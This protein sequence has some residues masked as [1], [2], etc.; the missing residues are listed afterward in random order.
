LFMV[1]SV[2]KVYFLGA[3]PGSALFLT[4]AGQALLNTADVVIYDALIDQ[5]LLRLSSESCIYLC[6]GKRGHQPSTAQADINRLL[7]Q[8]CRQGKQ[9]IRLKS[10]DPMFFGRIASE[11]SA[12]QAADCAYEVWPGLSSAI[13]APALAGI[14]LT[15]PDHSQMVTLVS[16][17]DLTQLNWM[18]LAQSETL[19]IL[20]GGRSLPDIVHR[21]QHQGRSRETPIAI[22]RWAGHPQQRLWQGTLDTIVAITEGESLSPTVMVIGEVVR[23]RDQL[24]IPVMAGETFNDM[25]IHRAHLN[26]PMSL[27]PPSPA[28]PL[29]GKTILVT[30]AAT[31]SGQF[32]DRLRGLGATVL[33]MAA[34]E[35]VAPS[36][37]EPLDRAIAQ[38]QTFD[39]LI[40]TSANGVEFFFQRL[41]ELGQDSRALATVKV[42]VVGR[43]TAEVLQQQGIVPDF[44]PP[45]Y[46]ADALVEHFPGGQNLQGLTCLFPRVESGGRET[47]TAELA[48]QGVHITEVAAY[49]SQCPKTVHPEVLD[50]LQQARVDVITFASSK[51]V[52]HFCQLLQQATG[53]EKNADAAPWRSWLA[54]V[55]IASIGPQTSRSCEKLLG[56]VD[57]EATEFTLD[58]L[59]QAMLDDSGHL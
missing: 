50:A 21:L 33:E 57:V 31:Q 7:V 47:L 5:K 53:M 12:L 8:Y 54:A 4:I 10:G 55:K 13:A 14:P 37:W 36:S 11:I 26:P 29:V 45:N 51:T 18:V 6:V 49:Q 44:I 2:G 15:D 30:R 27:H 56:R 35:I 19:V 24:K 52:D 38:L 23:L 48:V 22:I 46:V 39:W 42:A 34:L 41:R 16:A 3:G 43:K 25:M 20:M 59:I 9:V 17:H 40:L 32:S 1:H 58:G 28:P